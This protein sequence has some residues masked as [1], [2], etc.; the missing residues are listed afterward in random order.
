L[1]SETRTR[2]R[3]SPEYIE[4]KEE[5][6][7]FRRRLLFIGFFTTKLK[8]H[9]VNAI[10][11]GGEA[12]D[13][14]TGGTFASADIDLLVENKA[15]TEKLLNKFEFAKQGNT[16]WLNNELGFVVHLIQMDYSGD[17]DKLRKF[18]VKNHELR[19]AAPEDLIK[20]RLCSVKFWKSNPQRDMEE[21]VALL[22]I[23]SDSIDN[24]YL[25]KLAKEND[26]EDLLSD[27]RKYAS[28]V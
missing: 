27:A 20:D 5:K 1:G 25:D 28:T 11:V 21:S 22:K 10:L 15:I 14:Y 8:E 2:F 16:L 13:I 6:D 9:G 23:F 12:I 7:L 3:T 24:S 26:I 17:P 4:L 18:R 19:I